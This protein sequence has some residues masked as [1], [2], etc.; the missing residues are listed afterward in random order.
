MK[1][2]GSRGDNMTE[3]PPHTHQRTPLIED[4]RQPS[5]NILMDCHK[6]RKSHLVD[7]PKGHLIDL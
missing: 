5:A 3:S 1:P 4:I 6:K 2:R 7:G